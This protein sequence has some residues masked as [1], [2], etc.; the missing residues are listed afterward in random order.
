MIRLRTGV[1]FLL[2]YITCDVVFDYR[3]VC[4]NGEL[5]EDDGV[6]Y[7]PRQTSGDSV[8]GS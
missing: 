6:I 3:P 1:L 5:E 7:F 8:L 4:F 2:V